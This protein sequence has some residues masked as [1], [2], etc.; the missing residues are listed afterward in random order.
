MYPLT[1]LNPWNRN[2]AAIAVITTVTSHECGSSQLSSVARR[3]RTMSGTPVAS[4]GPV[5]AG[6][7]GA[8]S[9]SAVAVV[10]ER[11]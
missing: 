8:V 1:E 10:T 11:S 7:S 5:A 6:G 2:T 3:R 4:G 9:V